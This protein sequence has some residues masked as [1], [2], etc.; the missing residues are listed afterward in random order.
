M[1]PGGAALLLRGESRYLDA[2]CVGDEHMGRVENACIV[3]LGVE[4]ASVLD[5]DG[6]IG[7]T[8]SGL[9]SWYS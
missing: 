8:D 1:Q 7:S 6:V 2:M 3:C 9:I 4:D 5:G